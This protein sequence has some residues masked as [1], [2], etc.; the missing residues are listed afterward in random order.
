MGSQELRVVTGEAGETQNRSQIATGS[1]KHRDSRFA[2]YAFTEHGALM[3]AM[4]FPNAL[5][6]ASVAMRVAIGRS[7]SRAYTSAA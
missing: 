5:P 1:Q 7:R 6:N 2:P 4:E 3:S